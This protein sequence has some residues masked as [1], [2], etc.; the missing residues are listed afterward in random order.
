[1]PLYGISSV[2]KIESLFEWILLEFYILSFNSVSFSLCF[3][4]LLFGYFCIWH[5]F[6]HSKMFTPLCEII[7]S[8]SLFI[9]EYWIYL[10]LNYPFIVI[11]KFNN[12]LHN[13]LYI[14][15]FLF[16]CPWCGNCPSMFLTGCVCWG[17]RRSQKGQQQICSWEN[18]VYFDCGYNAIYSKIQEKFN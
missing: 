4:K 10:P 5:A 1:M 17:W 11:F 8:W 6:V 16:L 18:T 7:L 15:F 12:K 3:L 2:I 9:L 13:E 14:S